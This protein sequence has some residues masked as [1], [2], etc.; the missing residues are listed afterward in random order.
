MLEDLLKQ[1]AVEVRKVALM[2]QLRKRA[3]GRPD[4][5]QE[6]E[7]H[8]LSVQPSRPL[9]Y[10]HFHYN[11]PKPSFAEF[12]KAH[13][14]LPENRYITHADDATLPYADIG[15]RSAVLPWFE[16]L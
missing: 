9:W 4:H 2:K 7:I 13:L 6:Y 5:M 15:K 10:A 1:D 12:E 8:D 11:R 16:A 3:N 14:K